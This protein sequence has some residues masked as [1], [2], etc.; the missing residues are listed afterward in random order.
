MIVIIFS[1]ALAMFDKI[2]VNCN[3]IL[4][5]AYLIFIHEMCVVCYY[6]TAPVEGS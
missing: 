4:S 6:L 5:L 2:L 1:C 3:V